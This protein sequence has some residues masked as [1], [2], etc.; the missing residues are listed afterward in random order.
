MELISNNAEGEYKNAVHDVRTISHIKELISEGHEITFY[1]A[2]GSS[3]GIDWNNFTIAQLQSWGIE[4][5][6]IFFWKAKC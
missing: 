1:T 5:P 2:Q 6:C 4:N 3:T